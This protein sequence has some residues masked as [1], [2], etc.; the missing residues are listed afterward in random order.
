MIRKH[1]TRRGGAGLASAALLLAA[2]GITS[3]PAHARPAAGEAAPIRLVAGTFVPGKAAPAKLPGLSSLALGEQRAGTY[4]VQFDGPVREEWKRAVTAAGGDLLEYL[5]DFAFKLRATPAVARAIGELGGVSYIGRFDPSWKVAPSAKDKLAAGRPAVYRLSVEPRANGV[6]IRDAAVRAGA[7]V[8][9]ESGATVLVAGTPDQVRGLVNLDET[10]WIEKFQVPEKHNETA[11]AL[12]RIPAADARGYD[13]STQIAAVADT[14]LG[15][16][17]AATAHADIPAARI[18][19]IRSWTKP[20]AAGCYDVVGN[21]A[22]DV[23]SGHGTHVAV[24]VVGDGDA[25]GIGRAGAPAASLVF[26]AVEEYVDMQGQCE[27][28]DQRDGYYLFGLP[29]ALGDLF[30]EAYD[31]GARVHANSWG[32]PVAGAYNDNAREA[33]AFVNGH[34]DMAV[35]FSAGNSGTD[36]NR[37]G[38]VD[39]DSIGSPGT[40]KNVIT[41]GASENERA[42]YPCDRNLRYLPT[43]QKEI[44]T[45]GNRSCAQLD[46]ENPMPTWGDWWPN[47]YPVAP[48]STDR[49]ADNDQQVAAFSSRGPTNDGRIK[50][51]IVAPGSWIV[52]GYSDQYQQGYDAAANPRGNAWQHDGYGFPVSNQYKYF[53]G[54]SMSNPIAASGAVIVRDFYNKHHRHAAAS[55]ALV[56][57]TLINSADDLLDENGDG[58]DDNDFPIPN[59]HEGWGRINLDRATAGTAKYVDEGAGLATD[60]VREVR[61]QVAAGQPLRVS[62]AYTDRE[63]AVAAAV[64]LV[65]D[66]DL[67]VVAPNGTVYRGN[68]FAGG[69]TP[70]GG[71]ADRRNNVE[72]VYLQNPAAGTWTVR[73]RGFNVPN[74]PQTYALV[75]SG[76]VADPAPAPGGCTVTNGTDVNIADNT[77]VESSVVVAGCAGNASATSTV[78]V[79]IVHS[80]QGDLVVNLVAPDGTAYLLHNKAGAGTK[81]I[82]KTYPVNVSGEVANGTWKLRVQDTANGDVG[83]IDTWTL[84]LGGAVAGPAPCAGTNGTDVAVPDN[85]TVTS[86]ITLAG[87]AGNASATSTAE[88]HIVHSYQ[89]DLVVNLVAPDGTSYLLHNKAGGNAKDINRTYTVDASTEVRNGTWTLRVQDTANGD[90]GRI[91]TWTLTL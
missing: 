7:V 42:N 71:N 39:N 19:A 12:I 9:R 82:D 14:G 4:L 58:V 91:D 73:V 78:E 79:H 27:T 1:V 16:G 29:D 64:S 43:S 26:Q 88:V 84:S 61:Y 57:A 23:D 89:G 85:T 32:A 25:N 49:Q 41:V 8:V 37:D 69:W 86:T 74:G 28:E 72:N 90:V 76:S 83:R 65:N 20:D 48:L 59:S 51:D 3:L 80:Y 62:M 34:R 66:L 6:A 52:S 75:T 22:A 35:T 53:S 36:A 40:A 13:G 11:G 60:G 33:D 5:P 47:D 63:G 31:L 81:D 30:Q 24:S 45:T 77:T 70:A 50:P 56:K 55:A 18:T 38:V 21:G 15:G 68:V 17:T 87:C 10:G 46:G 2:L 54:T 67:E 44:D